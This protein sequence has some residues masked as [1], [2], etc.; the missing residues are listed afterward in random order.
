MHLE[1]VGGRGN[2]A[3]M[4]FWRYRR[5]CSWVRMAGGC[6]NSGV[7]L[8]RRTGCSI[9]SIKGPGSVFFFFFA[10]LQVNISHPNKQC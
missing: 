4:C 10:E 7:D 8:S 6:S 1:A 2:G 3:G 5:M 9:W